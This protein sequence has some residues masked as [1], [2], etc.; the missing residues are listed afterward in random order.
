MRVGVFLAAFLL[1]ATLVFMESPRRLAA[2]L[3]DMAA[4]LGPR[5]AAVGRELTKLYEEV[6]RGPLPELARHYGGRAGV[7]GEVIVVVA[8]PLPPEPMS[9]AEADRLLEAALRECSVRDAAAA[10]AAA[11]GLPKRR[12]YERALDIARRRP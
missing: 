10:V 11:T 7:R 8:P 3:G 1:P 6:R 5:E 9:D 12:L 4:V 2:S